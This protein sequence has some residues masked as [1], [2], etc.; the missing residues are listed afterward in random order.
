MLYQK[1]YGDV[2]YDQPNPSYLPN[3]IESAQY[4]AAV[5]STGA[6]RGTSKKNSKIKVSWEFYVICTKL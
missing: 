5:A 2:P 3:K 1:S 6:I 4:N